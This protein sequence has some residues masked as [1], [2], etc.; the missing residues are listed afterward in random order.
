V[1]FSNAGFAVQDVRVR[2]LGGE[3]R[4][5]GG[6]ATEVKGAS[7]VVLRINGTATTNALREMQDW[8]PVPA[9]MTWAAGSTTY[10]AVVGF[11]AG[12]PD[13]QVTT[14]LR[15][16]ALDL[17]FPLGKA[18]DAAW[19]LR[20]EVRR[21]QAHANSAARDRVRVA[22]ADRLA[23]DYELDATAQPARVLR[24]AVGVGPQAT[25]NLSLPASGVSAQLQ[26]PLLDVDAWEALSAR[27]SSPQGNLADA[28]AANPAESGATT[29]ARAYLPT[30]WEV[31]VG[32]LKVHERLL[33]DLVSNGVRE[34][35]TWRANLQ[36]REMAGRLA[37]SEGVNNRPGK[38]QARLTRL[39]VPEG[40][41]EEQAALLTEPPAN[42]P[43]LDIV[44]DDFELRG[45]KLG[46]LE[47]QAVNQ[48]QDWQLNTL[49][50]RMREATFTARGHWRAKSAS[51]GAPRRTELNFDL[52]VSDAGTLLTRLEMP[53]VL[54]RGKGSL[55]GTVGWDG[56][57]VSP[58][59]PSMSGQLHLDVGAGQF[60]KASP[61]VG[62]LL[63]VLSLQALPRRLSMDFRDV[64]SA[65][66][67]FD[68][69]RGDVR[70]QRGVAHTSNL[71]MKGVNAAVLMEGSADLDKET[72]DLR[73]L[74][75]PDID[76]GTAA[77]AAAVINPVVGLGAFVAQLI[78]KEPINR[79]ATREFQVDGSWANPQVTPVPLSERGASALA[80]ASTA[81]A[82]AP[83]AAASVPAWAETPARAPASMPAPAPAPASSAPL[84]PRVGEDS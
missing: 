77:L 36:S 29:A 78:L 63:G 16:I 40:T 9:L 35:A 53:G 34:G 10:D 18:V 70:V 4:I 8:A 42:M 30:A 22:L 72:Q 46:R 56:A 82:S 71:Q 15:G 7:P 62:K 61:G 33:H 76:A 39:V 19:P 75:V 84:S 45:K 6:T 80:A 17:P 47:V 64:F 49:S 5:S 60:L 48:D 68:F 50:L 79:A 32:E 1:A 24:G 55:S 67:A 11:H 44:A 74:V 31:R 59:Y 27:M 23:L 58:H 14:D 51:Q 41:S 12:G 38:L 2:A 25:R 21:Q 37:F 66:F 73:V 20:Y 26:L 28:S 54:A 57:P 52:D 3:A 65:G 81:A 69:V 43:A 83:A 13:V